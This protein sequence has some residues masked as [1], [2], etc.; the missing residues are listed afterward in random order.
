MAFYSLTLSLNPG[1]GINDVQ[2]VL[3]AFAT[4]Y[5]RIAPNTWIIL[6]HEYENAGAWWER[7]RHL[8][9]PSGTMFICRLDPGDRSGW[10]DKKFWEW[11]EVNGGT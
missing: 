11:L 9:H 1:L 6:A 7:L 4:T 8:V 3:G 10:I 5:Y 2:Q